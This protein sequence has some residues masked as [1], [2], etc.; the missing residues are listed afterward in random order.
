MILSHAAGIVTS[1]SIR[2]YNFRCP[3]LGTPQR[4]GDEKFKK[5]SLPTMHRRGPEAEV[6]PREQFLWFG[7]E[8][9]DVCLVGVKKII[10]A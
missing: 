10:Y 8:R 3:R 7:G 5:N 1:R 9:I 6:L 2:Y 4:I